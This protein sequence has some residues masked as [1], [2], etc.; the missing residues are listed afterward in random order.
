L[1]STQIRPPWLSTMCFTIERPRPTLL[2]IPN[3]A[4]PRR[5]VWE[6]GWIA[7]FFLNELRAKRAILEFLSL[8]H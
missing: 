8:M 5:Q 4:N 3:P 1:L 2:T 6:H 7:Q